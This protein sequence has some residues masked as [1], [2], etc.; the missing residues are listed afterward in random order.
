MNT[1][2]INKQLTLKELEHYS[3]RLHIPLSLIENTQE[4]YF[5]KL[6]SSSQLKQLQEYIDENFNF[7]F[8]YLPTYRRI[9]EELQSIFKGLDELEVKKLY[10]KRSINNKTNF[11]EM[12]E[13]GMNDV[14]QHIN[15]TLLK[16]NNFTRE[17]LNSLTSV[18]LADIIDKKI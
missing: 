11:L 4:E 1:L 7:W 17:N 10:S 9:E 6:K 5:R 12:I 2:F 16:L 14:S 18:Y 8:L 13:F 3:E 15:D